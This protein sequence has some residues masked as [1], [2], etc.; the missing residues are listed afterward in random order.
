MGQVI[1][2]KREN[3]DSPFEVRQDELHAEGATLG[4]A[5]D[6]L[7]DQIGELDEPLLLVP[8]DCP[9]RFFTRQDF[10]RVK[11]LQSR[12]KGQGEPLNPEEHEELVALIAK[13]FRATIQRA[14]P[15]VRQQAA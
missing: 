5:L 9:D 14:Q 7:L 1:V 2:I 13:E 12:A 10:D 3:T 6:R 8:Q 11:A 15:L 4:A